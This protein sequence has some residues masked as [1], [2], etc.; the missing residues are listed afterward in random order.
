MTR[1]RTAFEIDEKDKRFRAVMEQSTKEFAVSDVPHAL[2]CLLE[3]FG[4][5]GMNVLSAVR[6]LLISRARGRF[7][8]QVQAA[9]FLGVTERVMT[10]HCYE[11]NVLEVA[12]LLPL[13]KEVKER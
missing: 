12:K 10:Y 13:P 11:R 9:R 5:R 6:D 7:D 3:F 4:G 1:Q 8:T 2:D